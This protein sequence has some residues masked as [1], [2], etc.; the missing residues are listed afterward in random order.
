[1]LFSVLMTCL[2]RLVAAGAGLPFV[3]GDAAINVWNKD[4]QEC[5]VSCSFENT[6]DDGDEPHHQVC[7]CALVATDVISAELW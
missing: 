7:A 2:L 6:S 3:A 4:T 1:M 5:R